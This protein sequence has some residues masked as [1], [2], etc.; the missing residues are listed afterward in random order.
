MC[1]PDTDDDWGASTDRIAISAEF[2][3]SGTSDST[4]AA[5]KRPEP[6]DYHTGRFTKM[7][8]LA[9]QLQVPIPA[10]RGPGSGIGP[11]PRIK[12]PHPALPDHRLGLSGSGATPS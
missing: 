7:A 12:V 4:V 6:V 9:K 1:M 5:V 10:D 11:V 3:S 2:S 8:G